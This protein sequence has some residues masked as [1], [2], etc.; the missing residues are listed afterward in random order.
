MARHWTGLALAALVVA[1][2]PATALFAQ[3]AAPAA[4]DAAPTDEARVQKGRVLFADWGCT[5]C[6]ALVDAKSGGDVGPHLDGGH[7]T[8]AFIVGR[9]TNG[10]GAMPGF[11]GQLTEP[12]IADIAYYITKVAKKAP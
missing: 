4:A 6:H 7:L 9:V 5:S 12:E 10:Q 1:G 3:Q 11:G 2:V 8:E